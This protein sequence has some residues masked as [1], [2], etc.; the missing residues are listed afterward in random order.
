MSN[1]T[2]TSLADMKAGFPPA[3]ELILG[4]PNLQSFIDL[5][6]H[7]CRCAQTHQSPASTKMNLF[8]CAA[9]RNVY[10]FLSSEAY[11][12]TYTPFPA[13]VPDVPDLAACT[14]DND[15]ATVR[16]THARDKKTRADIITMNTALAD[17]FFEAISAQVRAP[18]QQQP[19][20]RT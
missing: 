11:P 4:I 12:D 10:A 7:L 13:E 9:P 1:L 5:L 19:L 2:E 16:A 14:N 8:F 3:P 6:F 20:L 15:P 18:I 17:I